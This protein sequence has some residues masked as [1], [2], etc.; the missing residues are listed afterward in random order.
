MKGKERSEHW[1]DLTRPLVGV[2]LC[3]AVAVLVAAFTAPH[4]WRVFVPL[5]FVAIIVLLSVRYG[6]LVSIF[7]SLIAA[8]VF[9]YFLFPPLGSVRVS[10]STDR[11][12]LGWMLLGGIVISYLLS[13]PQSKERH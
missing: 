2:L 12:N 7:G 5:G 4:P 11:S 1:L 9:A 8:V 10:A 13:P 3:A 6:I